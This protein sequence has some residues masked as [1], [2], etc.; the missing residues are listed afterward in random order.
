M[1]KNVFTDEELEEMIPA[2]RA[3]G[4]LDTNPWDQMAA[5]FDAQRAGAGS[6]IE[7]RPTVEPK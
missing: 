2:A 5:F 1:N 7:A 3:A 6:Q 4:E